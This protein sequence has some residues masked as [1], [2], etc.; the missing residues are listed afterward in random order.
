MKQGAVPF[1]RT[2][3]PQ[4]CMAFDSTNP[5]YGV[6]CNPHNKERSCGGSSGGM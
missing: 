5:I 6:T 2:N 3:I 4:T 1:I